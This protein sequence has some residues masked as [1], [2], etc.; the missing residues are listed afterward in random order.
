MTATERPSLADAAGPSITNFYD[1]VVDHAELLAALRV[2][3]LDE[4][5]AVL[6]NRLRTWIRDHPDD[7]RLLFKG[8]ETLTRV[9]AA[10]HRI[11]GKPVD[12]L[13]AAIDALTRSLHEQLAPIDEV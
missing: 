5:L 2:E 9:V 10:R 12:Q 11:S 6:R 8:I 7:A 13:G 1:S 3:G 4:E